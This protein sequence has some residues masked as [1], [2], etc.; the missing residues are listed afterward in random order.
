[1]KTRTPRTNTSRWKIILAE[2]RPSRNSMGDWEVCNTAASFRIPGTPIG[3]LAFPG[4][5]CEWY[6]L[7]RQLLRRR[8]AF[9]HPRFL[10]SPDAQLQAVHI[11]INNRSR[12]EGEHLTN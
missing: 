1:M 12:I 5:L 4:K 10:A 11:Q 8:L 7:D 3:R 2:S 9:Q 6:S